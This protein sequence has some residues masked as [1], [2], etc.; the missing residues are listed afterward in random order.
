MITLGELD[1]HVHVYEE[2]DVSGGANPSLI[3][4]TNKTPPSRRLLPTVPLFVA[5]LTGGNVGVTRERE[6]E[7]V[8]ATIPG[9]DM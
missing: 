3:D 9:D 6:Q 4:G 5:P 8:Y 7:V 2:I 1:E